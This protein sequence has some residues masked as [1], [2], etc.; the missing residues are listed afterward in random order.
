MIFTTSNKVT[1]P[2]NHRLILEIATGDIDASA[3]LAVLHN[4]K[5]Q[6]NVFGNNSVLMWLS[7]LVGR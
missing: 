6:N 1:L 7:E 4:E 2:S 3:L 5:G